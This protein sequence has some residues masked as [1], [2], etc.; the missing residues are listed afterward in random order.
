MTTSEQPSVINTRQGNLPRMANN[1]SRQIRST[2]ARRPAEMRSGQP[3]GAEA[4]AGDQ[5]PGL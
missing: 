3:L 2:A 4:E 5:R 1:A